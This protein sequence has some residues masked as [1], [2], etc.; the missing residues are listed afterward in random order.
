VLRLLA[1]GLDHP[2]I[3]HQHGID[4]RTSRSLLGAAMKTLGATNTT[5]AVTLAIA[6][7]HIPP[8]IALQE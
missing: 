1:R 6:H 8:D 2:H 5:H 4:I 7:G 3:E